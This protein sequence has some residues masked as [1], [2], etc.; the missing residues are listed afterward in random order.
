MSDE[1]P[2]RIR[3]KSEKKKPFIIDT[4]KSTKNPLRILQAPFSLQRKSR[5]FLKRGM[6]S[7]LNTSGKTENQR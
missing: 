6:T 7:P 3:P 5:I 2:V 4:I 1:I